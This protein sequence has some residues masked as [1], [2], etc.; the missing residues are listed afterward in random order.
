MSKRQFA[1]PHRG[2]GCVY[3]ADGELLCEWHSFAD[4]GSGLYPCKMNRNKRAV[5]GVSYRIYVKSPEKGG[6]NVTVNVPKS[7][8]EA[9]L[10]G[11]E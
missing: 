1:I 11:E 7:C 3:Q 5:D 4:R 6:H 2:T 10:E 9:A 8:I